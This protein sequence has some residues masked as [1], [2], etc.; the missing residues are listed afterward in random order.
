M[1]TVVQDTSF[2]GTVVL[3]TVAQKRP[4]GQ[5]AL[6][7]TYPVPWALEVFLIL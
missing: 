1:V 2:G 3:L 4:W 7:I 6:D 5:R